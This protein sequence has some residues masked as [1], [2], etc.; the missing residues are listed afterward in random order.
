VPLLPLSLLPRSLG[1]PS[2]ARIPPEVRQGALMSTERAAVPLRRLR[3]ARSQV[4]P[5]EWRGQ[6]VLRGRSRAGRLARQDQQV[7]QAAFL[8]GRLARQALRELPVRSPEA[9]AGR[10]DQ[11][12]QRVAYPEWAAAASQ[13]PDQPSSVFDSG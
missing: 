10:P 4:V 11:K 7:P 3:Q 6:K 13:R 1:L 9:R 8:A 12:V 2:L 5:V